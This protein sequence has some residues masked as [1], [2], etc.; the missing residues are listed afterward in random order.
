MRPHLNLALALAAVAALLAGP[1][2]AGGDRLHAPPSEVLLTVDEALEL[3]FGETP[4]VKRTHYLT[5]EQRAAVE[6]LLG[7]ELE[8]AVARPY[9]ARDE[10]GALIGVAWFDT[11]RVRTKRETVMTA[12]DADG[13][14]LRVEVLAFAEPKRYLLKD[15]FYA[16]FDGEALD[17]DLVLDGDIRGVSGATLTA[18]ATVEAARRALALHAVLFPPSVEEEGDEGQDDDRDR[19]EVEDGDEGDAAAP[20]R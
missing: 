14:V 15:A 8:S 10:D 12:I 19:D 7:E 9:V 2:P 13:E 1:A 18:R 17:D 20:V 5:E 3:V 4:A 6:D 16:Q 11:H